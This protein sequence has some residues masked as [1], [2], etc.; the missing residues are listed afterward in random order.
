M[1]EKL[2]SKTGEE[3]PLK[4]CW[5]SKA[6]SAEHLEHLRQWMREQDEIVDKQACDKQV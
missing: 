6:E 3:V 2:A 5:L 1:L 4:V